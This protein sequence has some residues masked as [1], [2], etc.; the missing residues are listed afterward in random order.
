MPFSHTAVVDNPQLMNRA[1]F[2]NSCAIF[3]GPDE[4]ARIPALWQDHREKR[5]S[6]SF[7]DLWE[8][9]VS[10]KKNKTKVGHFSLC[11]K[12]APFPPA[13]FEMFNDSES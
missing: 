7:E 3:R 4:S 5:E 9:A 8:E 6:H 11:N 1:T 13:H 12:D 10:L 2:K